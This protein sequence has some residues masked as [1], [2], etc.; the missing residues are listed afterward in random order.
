MKPE[1]KSIYLGLIITSNGIEMDP[2]KVDAIVNWRKP[3]NLRELQRFLGF[4]NFYRRFVRD[5]SRICR[6]LNDLLRKD[7]PWN[8][9][10]P[11]TAAFD[12]LKSSFMTAPILAFFDYNKT[13]L[14]ETGF[15][16]GVWW[17]LIP[18][19]RRRSPATSSILLVKTLTS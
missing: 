19:R 15:G 5:F 17:H 11:H 16:L 2:E 7:T 3:P 18:I 10:E 9:A 6:P 4:A 8:W 13:S 14:L 12:L 1:C